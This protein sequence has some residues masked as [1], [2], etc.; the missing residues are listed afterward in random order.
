M[1]FF[2]LLFSFRSLSL[3][4]DEG[5]RK[6]KDDALLLTLCDCKTLII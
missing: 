4:T 6:K 1:H 3:R 2:L 5:E